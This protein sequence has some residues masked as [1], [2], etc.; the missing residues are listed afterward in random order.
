MLPLVRW[1]LELDAKLPLKMQKV[2]TFSFCF[3][4]PPCRNSDLLLI[5]VQ[6]ITM[7]CVYAVDIQVSCLHYWLKVKVK[8]QYNNPWYYVSQATANNILFGSSKA[9]TIILGI[10]HANIYWKGFVLFG[11][12]QRDVWCIMDNKLHLCLWHNTVFGKARA[13]A[14]CTYKISSSKNSMIYVIFLC[15][16]MEH[17]QWSQLLKAIEAMKIKEASSKTSIHSIM[18]DGILLS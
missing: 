2:S 12:P 1:N 16:M 9:K 5:P 7:Q 4:S 18:K 10:K 17:T 15:T 8:L 13:T 14:G 6:Y 3:S 11:D